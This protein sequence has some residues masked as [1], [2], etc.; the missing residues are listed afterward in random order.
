MS[1][2]TVNGG[3][4]KLTI[5][6]APTG[7]HLLVHGASKAPLKITLQPDVGLTVADEITK[8]CGA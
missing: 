6:P 7:C 3:E 1:T 5:E 2:A 4:V 8:A